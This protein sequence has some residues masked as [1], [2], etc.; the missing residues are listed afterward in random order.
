MSGPF[1]SMTPDAKLFYSRVFNSAM[2]NLLAVRHGH[3]PTLLS[4]TEDPGVYRLWMES[5][6]KVMLLLRVDGVL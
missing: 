2:L 1:D 3:F 6:P 5:L 4:E